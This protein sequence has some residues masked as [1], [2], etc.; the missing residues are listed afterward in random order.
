[1]RHGRPCPCV[2]CKN[3]VVPYYTWRRHGR[4]LATGVIA[5]WDPAGVEFK[6]PVEDVDPDVDEDEDNVLTHLYI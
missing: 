6:E 4:K 1:M 5:R 2:Q 3:S